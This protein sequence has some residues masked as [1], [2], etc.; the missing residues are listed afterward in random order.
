[1]ECAAAGRDRTKQAPTRLL[2]GALRRGLRWT[3]GIGLWPSVWTDD[4]ASAAPAKCD[5]RVRAV[6]LAAQASATSPGLKLI[7]MSGPPPFR[8]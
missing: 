3:V 1:M 4:R 5:S 6:R 8:C 2:D 7:I